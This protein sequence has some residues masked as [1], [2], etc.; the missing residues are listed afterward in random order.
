MAKTSLSKK[1]IAQI[2]GAV[3]HYENDFQSYVSLT[4]RVIADFANNQKL[5]N[6][7]HSSKFRTKEPGHLRDKLIRIAKEAK[8]KG[9][10]FNISEKNIFTKINDLA[11]VRLLHVHTKEIESIH[12]IMLDIIKHFKYKLPL[13]PVAY[14]WDIENE[15]LFKH[16]GFRTILRPSMYTS[17]H[18]V[19]EPY[20]SKQRCEIQVRTLMEEL[21]GEVSHTI[22]YPHET[23]SIPCKEQLRALARLASGCTRLVDSIFISHDLHKG[24]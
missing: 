8:K 9:R 24:N 22:N 6:L 18:Y 15:Q 7:I 16:V 17:V 13:K 4:S 11:G 21:W 3:V 23:D 1:V 20:Y 14:T 19:V 12:P 2:E 5:K 10:E